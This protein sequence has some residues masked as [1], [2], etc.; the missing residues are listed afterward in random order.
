MHIPALAVSA[1]AIASVLSWATMG[2]SGAAGG[3]GVYADWTVDGTSASA[4]LSG[5]VFPGITAARTGGS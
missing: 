4:T 1:V 2:S 3:T 5:T